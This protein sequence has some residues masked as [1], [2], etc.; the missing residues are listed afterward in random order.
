M[1]EEIKLNDARSEKDLYY[2]PSISISKIV[3]EKVLITDQNNLKVAGIPVPTERDSRSF[4]NR[5]GFLFGA[6]ILLIMIGLGSIFSDYWNSNAKSVFHAENNSLT[7]DIISTDS[8]SNLS[9]TLRKRDISSDKILDST[10]VIVVGTFR[11]D[12][13]AKEML[14]RLN[15]MGHTGIAEDYKDLIRIGIS[16]TCEGVNLEEYL[17]KIRSELSQSAWYLRPRIDF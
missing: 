3:K 1:K 17:N 4:A 12:L 16:F 13:N 15:E 7:T 11:N 14:N 2:L 5:F 8:I 6:I 9:Q 10:C